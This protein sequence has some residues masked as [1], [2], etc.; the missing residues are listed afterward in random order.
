MSHGPAGRPIEGKDSTP[1]T[2]VPDGE[3]TLLY[4]VDA[5]TKGSIL[6]IESHL[7]SIATML[8]LLIGGGASPRR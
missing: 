6:A 7:E 5:E 8:Q 4:V 1:A 3:R 2:I